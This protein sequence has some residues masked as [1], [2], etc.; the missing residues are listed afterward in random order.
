MIHEKPGNPTTKKGGTPMP[1]P[2]D[3]NQPNGNGERNH[4]LFPAKSPTVESISIPNDG[5]RVVIE[6]SLRATIDLSS[7]ILEF[8][9]PAEEEF[10]SEFELREFNLLEAEIY[11]NISSFGEHHDFASTAVLLHKAK[12]FDDGLY[13]AIEVLLENETPGFPGKRAILNSILDQLSIDLDRNYDFAANGNKKISKSGKK[14][15]LL[16]D[17]PA[18]F[19]AKKMDED[20]SAANRQDTE[21]CMGLI[22]AGLTLGGAKRHVHGP[23]RER[24][25]TIFHNFLSNELASKPIGFYTWSAELKR[26]FQQD[27]ILQQNLMPLGVKGD[28]ELFQKW[29]NRI[30][31]LSRAIQNSDT[32]DSYILYLSF[33]HK[34]TNPFPPEYR[35][36]PLIGEIK[37]ELRYAVFPPSQSHETELLKK[38]FPFPAEIPEGF[39]LID[40]LIDA[41]QKEEISL[42][43]RED[44]GWYD[45]QVYAL[46]PLV[47]PDQM[48]ESRHVKLTEAYKKEMI[49]LFKAAIA[50]T[51][52]THV[53]Q[54]ESPMC[55][56]PGPR[57]RSIK[58]FPEVHLEPHAELFLRRGK[59]YSFIR[60]ALR[61]MFSEAELRQIRRIRPAGPPDQSLW[62]ELADM[63]A[64]FYGAY[65]IISREL[66]MNPQETEG[67][68]SQADMDFAFR[69]IF[70][71][72]KD[73]DIQTDGRMMV[74]LFDDIGRGKTKVWVFLGYRLEKL[75]I[76]FANRLEA[77]FATLSGDPIN[78]NLEYHGIQRPLIVPVSAEIYVNRIFNREE[79]QKMCN[80]Y[81]NQSKI[82]H[83]L[84][85][86]V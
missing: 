8:D 60:E 17:L 65:G 41:I 14:P 10:L 40:S 46:E 81:R 29:K 57:P 77:E 27:R 9:I 44:S 21:Y 15:G 20:G 70:S 12:C 24:A 79:F 85:N 25:E 47:I 43:P 7:Q 78:A 22:A 30:E 45:H 50:L 51:R 86:I 28:E 73:L 61:D 74:P 67:R 18:K 16:S 5:K 42:L 26:I 53:K 31:I 48:P 66:G 6:E 84:E 63:E 3:P 68:N 4:H 71:F 56:S 64:L 76:H 52:E 2:A 39:T 38:L 33:L 69:W 35:S 75:E 54:L 36:F 32:L 49:A 82:L 34:L 59:A 13:A 23:V 58:I 37:E 55:G 80:R 83:V 1:I 11:P 62:E 72:H 19:S